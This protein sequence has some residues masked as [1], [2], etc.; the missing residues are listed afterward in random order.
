MI[1]ISK[2]NLE[3]EKVY[4]IKKTPDLTNVECVH[5]ERYYLYNKDGIE[6]RFQKRNNA[7]ELQRLEI[8]SKLSRSRKE[9][10]ISEVEFNKLKKNAVG[11]MLR[12]GYYL[13]QDPQ[14]VVRIYHGK[15][16]GLKRVEVE[17][18]SEKQAQKYELPNW[19]GKEISGTALARDGELISLSQKEFKK[20]FGK[21]IILYQEWD[22]LDWLSF[23]TTIIIS[24]MR[25]STPRTA[26]QPL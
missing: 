18:K 8:V 10:K 6:L 3:I 5:D 20:L 25:F 15:Y 13:S 7:F 16:E 22:K 11:P 14:V 17:F 24:P 2:S 26:N 21:W 9:M 4:L 12:D 19:F 1:K 23:R